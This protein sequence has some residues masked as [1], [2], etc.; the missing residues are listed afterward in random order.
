MDYE[1]VELRNVLDAKIGEAFVRNIT[2]EKIY[3]F[4]VKM[5]GANP[6]IDVERI[7]G[8]TGYV[9][10]AQNSKVKGIVNNPS[11]FDTGTPYTKEYT[12]MAI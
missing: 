12:N 7:K 2:P 1:M 8:Q 3:L 10:V 9:T 5:D 11:I 4:G 6:F